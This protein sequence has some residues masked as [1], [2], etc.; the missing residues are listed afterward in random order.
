VVA[1][2][3]FSRQL[4]DRTNYDEGVYLASLDALR[5]GAELGK[6]VFASQPPGFYVL[7][8]FVG[9]FAGRSIVDIRIGMLVVAMLGVA[10]AFF[11][12]R[13]LAGRAGAVAAAALAIAAPPFASYAARVEADTPSIA[14]ALVAVAVAACS[15]RPNALWGP[16]AAGALAAAAVSVKLLALPVVVPLA[17]LA[18]Q[19]RI[20]LRALIAAAAGAL[21]VASVLAIVYADA[22]PQLWH[23]AVDFQRASGPLPVG[24]SAGTRLVRYFSLRT[25]TTWGVAAGI[26]G[27]LAFRRQLALWAFAAAAVIFLL[28]QAPLLDHHFVLLAAAIGVAAGASLGS[29][30]RRL[31]AVATAAALV[32]AFGG[33][34][35]DVRQIDRANQPES[36]DVRQAAATVRAL[37]NRHDL[38][39]SDL[40]IVPYL[41]DRREPGELVDTSALRFASG[42]LAPGDVRASS[43]RIV[44]AGREFLRYPATISGLKLIRRIGGIE[45]LTR[46]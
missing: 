45:I 27:A 6:D 7:L 32:V 31:G 39:A 15:F 34:I 23:D 21:A 9:L 2:F 28:L 33:W 17:V 24:E 10:A 18:W 38:V 12:G 11:I 8:R 16:S 37:T 44:V 22:L 36:S 26:V 13:F 42:S 43:A 5:H 1:G 46:P 3:V 4:D 29:V 40:P 35:Q 19:R 14:V 41:A 25:P 30:P 20:G